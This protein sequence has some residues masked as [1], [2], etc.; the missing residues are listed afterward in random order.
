MPKT[1][2]YPGENGF[3]LTKQNSGKEAIWIYGFV[4]EQG[5]TAVIVNTVQTFKRSRQLRLKSKSF[6][7]V[8]ERALM[9]HRHTTKTQV[10]VAAKIV[11][12][13]IN[14]ST[15]VDE[16]QN[17]ISVETPARHHG[18]NATLWGRKNITCSVAT[19]EK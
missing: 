16:R 1:Q 10:K 19:E 18:A 8:L 15:R 12:G 9:T 3:N 13:Q 2:A 14:A 5:D 6:G 4:N 11:K 7:A 17:R